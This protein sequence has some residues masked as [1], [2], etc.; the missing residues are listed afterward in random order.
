[1][2][3]IAFD[4]F[5]TR[6]DVSSLAGPMAQIVPDAASLLRAWRDKQLEYSFLLPLMGRYIRSPGSRGAPWRSSSSE[7][8]ACSTMP[9]W[10]PS[11]SSGIASPVPRRGSRPE[12]LRSRYRLVVL[13]N[14]DPPLLVKALENAQLAPRFEALLSAD[15]VKT[16]KPD[17]RV[18]ALASD[19]L[20]MPKADL[21]LVSSNSF[22]VMGAKAAGLRAIWVTRQGCRS[23]ALISFP[24]SN[25]GTSLTS[26]GASRRF[27]YFGFRGFCRQRGRPERLLWGMGRAHSRWPRERTPAGS[28]PQ[29]RYAFTSFTQFPRRSRRT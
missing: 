9:R 17:P 21:A 24:T 15:A 20:R 7:A 12:S 1:M 19:R 5:G 14:A 29:L 22:D 10:K 6:L 3:A 25:C 4:A 8:V 23:S 18:Y 11:C 16:F 27:P 2:R 26:P 13:S 28:E